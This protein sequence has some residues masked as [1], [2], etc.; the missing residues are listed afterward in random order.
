M[1]V[2]TKSTLLKYYKR[3]EIQDAI[4]EHGRDKEIGVRYGDSFGKRPDTLTYPREIIELALK[5]ATSLHASEERWSNPLSLDS[6]LTKKDLDQ[7]RIG[8]DLLLDIDCKIFEYSRICAYL[9]VE[10]LKYCEVKDYSVKFSVTGDTPVLVKFNGMIRLMPIKECITLL[11]EKKK[12]QILSLDKCG[13]VCFLTITDYLEHKDKICNIY[14][15][16]STVPIKATKYHSVFI[17]KEGKIIEKAVEELKVGNHLISFRNAERIRRDNDTIFRWQYQFRN[18]IL[19]GKVKV[20]L[21]LMHLLGYYI[22]EGHIT[23]SINQIGFSFNVNEKRYIKRCI[24]LLREITKRKISIRHPNRNTTQILIHSKEW[25]AFFEKA[26]GKGAKNKHLPSF[27]WELPS[28]YFK[29]LLLGYLEGDGYKLGEYSITAKSVSHQLI[30]ELIW[31]C[32]LNKIGCSLN[33]ETN[34]GH[35]LPQGNMFKGSNVLTINIPKSELEGTSF[36]RGQNKYSPSVQ[37]KT[38]PIDGLKRVYAQIKPKQFNHYRTEQMTLQKDSASLKRIN[39]VLNWFEKT[40]AV[41]Y[42]PESLRI[43][44]D[45]RNLEYKDISTLKIKKIIS[46]GEEEVFD[47][48]V[49]GTERFFGGDYPVLLHNSGNK[50]FHIAVPFEAFPSKVGETPTRLLFPDAAK[51]IAL[52]VRDH[53]AGELARRIMVLEENNFTKVKEKVNLP[54]EEIIRYTQNQMG[55]KVA[56]LN[57][58]KFLEIDT[59]LLSSRHLYRMPYSLHEKSG[60]ASLPIDPEKIL[61]FERVM[62]EPDLIK[63]EFVFMNRNV[64]GESARRLLVQAL[65]YEIKLVDSR[66]KQRQQ[67]DYDELVINSPIKEDFF[68]PCMKIMLQGVADGKKRAIFC[69]SGFLGKIGWN[70]EQIEQFLHI[71]NNEKNQPPLR[72]VYLKGQ[73]AH[74]NPGERL[75]P[76]CNNDAYYKGIGVCKPDGLCGKIKNPVNYTLIRWKRYLQDREEEEQKGKRGRKKKENVERKEEGNME[77]KEVS[78]ER[79]GEEMVNLAKK[80]GEVMI[81][82][83][84]E[85]GRKVN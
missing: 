79:K 35:L 51:K 71:W 85:E 36:F 73:L 62:A 45:Y 44:T 11:K 48:S 59:V 1:S 18:K 2:L 41:D 37:N 27:I 52:Y 74:F 22:S 43:I 83:E 24:T 46:S 61:S 55:D 9:V 30:R 39:N 76:N 15:E 67:K 77:T 70:K 58:D 78:E 21:K 49:R 81:G 5:G 64:S 57:I 84:K 19:D 13:K 38:F 14:F 50:G 17:W 63:P 6:T 80:E 4:I 47:V 12:G 25:Y 56:H 82:K 10:F 29:V 60:L 31:A 26:C 53:I 68:P 34:K 72:E 16:N 42:T 7:L 54:A 40:K 75:P 8:W 28:S 3:K 32:N 33:K 23:R 66:E 20:T 69:M 65:D